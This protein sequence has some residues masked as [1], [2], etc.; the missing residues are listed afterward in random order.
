MELRVLQRHHRAEAVVAAGQLDHD[1]NL[2]VGD[3]FLLG[4]VDG[5]GEGVRHGG[6]TR[7]QAGGAGAEDEARLEEVTPLELVDAVLFSHRCS[8]LLEL[9]FR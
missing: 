6:V 9:E 1:Q 3:P 5:A 8:H 2:V 4:R 7:G